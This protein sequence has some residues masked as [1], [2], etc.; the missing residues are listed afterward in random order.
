MLRAP[1]WEEEELEELGE[2]LRQYIKTSI[3]KKEKQK[4]RLSTLGSP[5]SIR[6]DNLVCAKKPKQKIQEK[7]PE[8]LNGSEETERV[9]T[10]ADLPW[11]NKVL[12]YN[13]KNN[14]YIGTPKPFL[15]DAQGANRSVRA[16]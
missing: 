6:V 13:G 5:N 4:L 8:L 11:N 7:K 16:S 10:E 3:N 9:Y 15:R 12:V 2:S 1:K 14:F